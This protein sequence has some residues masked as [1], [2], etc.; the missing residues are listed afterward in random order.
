MRGRFVCNR[1]GAVFN[2]PQQVEEDRGEFWGIPCTETMY[3][4]PECGR[5]DFEECCADADDIEE[6]SAED[7][8]LEEQMLDKWD[9]ERDLT[10]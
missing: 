3:Y 8:E 6:D 7:R 2:A 10:W 1:C 4:C 9:K 5:D